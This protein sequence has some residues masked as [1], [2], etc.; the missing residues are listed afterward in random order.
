VR[1]CIVFICSLVAPCG[2]AVSCTR[3]ARPAAGVFNL[4]A[5]NTARLTAAAKK[6]R[7]VSEH[8]NPPWGTGKTWREGDTTLSFFVRHFVETTLAV[9]AASRGITCDH[10][11]S[12]ARGLV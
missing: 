5:D 8:R 9:S 1:K 3:L 6:L 12:L 4:R 10:V 7:D 2:H 11:G